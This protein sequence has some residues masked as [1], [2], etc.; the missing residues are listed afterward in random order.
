MKQTR[1]SI[2]LCALFL[3]LFTV[4]SSAQSART[5]VIKFDI[6]NYNAAS[7]AINEDQ[8][9]IFM[10]PD[11][12]INVIFKDDNNNGILEALESGEITLVVS[13]SGGRADPVEV[14]VTPD[15]KMNGL[16]ITDSFFST[17][18]GSDQSETFKIPIQATIDIPTDSITFDIAV[19]EN[20]GGFDAMA[21]L[22]MTT[23]G[24]P[25]PN[26]KVMGVRIV[27]SG[28][29]LRTVKADGKMQKGETAMA[30]ITI[31]N[32][33]QG[34]ANDVN[35][36]IS[37]TDPN[38]FILN[39]RGMADQI[40]GNLK[41]LKV[42][43]SIE[44]PVRISA[45]YRYKQ[46]Q[47]QYLPFTLSVQEKY[48]QGNIIAEVLPIALDQMPQKAKLVEVVP[49]LQKITS[50]KKTQLYSESDKFSS[51]I[52]FKDVHTAPLGTELYPNA[53]AVV[54]GAGTNSNNIPPA[55]Y[56][57]NDANIMENYFMNTMGVKKIIKITDTEVTRSKLMDIFAAYGDLSRYVVPGETDIFV[58]Y[59]GHGIPDK[60]ADGKMDV[61]LI[62]DDCRKDM[63]S[64]RGYSLN[65]LY[66]SL[67]DV[68]AKSVTVILDACFSGSSRQSS[69]YEGQSISN[70]KGIDVVIEDM[71]VKPW[72]TNE[73][74]R[75]LTS[76]SGDQTSLAFDQSQSGLFTYYLALG[77]QGDAD[78]DGD[79][80]ITLEELNK[81]VTEQVSKA[82]RQI[83]NG[84]QTPQLLGNGNIVIA[85]Y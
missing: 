2:M 74:F 15:R 66:S 17:S 79:K 42:G 53:I 52:K 39:D 70:M 10:F 5:R 44:I 1:Q 69:S 47:G 21:K 35:Y 54:I 43:E 48:N 37:K 75:V 36:T 85:Q 4:C 49:D 14:Q 11:L 83:R 84:N 16:V 73:N 76:S 23:F 82:A 61:Y 71:G 32:V 58:Y 26:L 9:E 28:K 6:N 67:N 38:I 18:I 81:Y 13:N 3:F 29:G 78:S 20:V 55:P 25:K 41:D 8:M 7:S 63:L 57:A 72:M 34:I 59:S 77:M 56:A 22:K 60:S 31:Q 65:K 51:N 40:N 33:G 46:V 64:E 45:N 68:G 62:P 12:N 19:R 30:Y 50:L 27:D 80:T 24:F